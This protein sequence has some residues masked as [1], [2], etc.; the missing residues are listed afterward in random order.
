M[1]KTG[2]TTLQ[3]KPPVNVGGAAKTLKVGAGKK[4]GPAI[5]GKPKAK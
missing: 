1:A 3:P 2:K 4:K 5:V